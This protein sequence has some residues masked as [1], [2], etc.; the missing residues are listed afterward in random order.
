[1]PKFQNIQNILILF[2]LKGRA[3]QWGGLPA[4]P[5]RITHRKV[6]FS[7]SLLLRLK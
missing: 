1:M 6:K 2:E 5:R 3:T 4:P 7:T